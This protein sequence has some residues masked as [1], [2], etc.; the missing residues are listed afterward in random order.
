MADLRSFHGSRLVCAP[1]ESSFNLIGSIFN[2]IPA[3]GRLKSSAR[4]RQSLG[5][6]SEIERTRRKNRREKWRLY[7]IYFSNVSLLL[8]RRLFAFVGSARLGSFRPGA[9]HHR[10]F[11]GANLVSTELS[12]ECTRIALQVVGVFMRARENE[13]AEA[14]DGREKH[15]VGIG[16]DRPV[17]SSGFVRRPR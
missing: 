10:P 4:V 5:S 7:L 8:G 12:R 17:P 1:A 3:R 13:E 9:H 11:R 2:L 14:K 16:P 15:A 6:K